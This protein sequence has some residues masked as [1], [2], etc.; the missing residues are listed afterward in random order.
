MQQGDVQDDVQGEERGSERGIAH[1]SQPQHDER[2]PGSGA[3]SLASRKGTLAGDALFLESCPRCAYATDPGRK[4]N[5][6]QQ[7]GLDLRVLDPSRG[8]ELLCV[9]CGYDLSSLQVR[10]MCPECATPVVSS[11]SVSR[12]FML[13]PVAHL[14]R[15]YRGLLWI[16]VAS[17]LAVSLAVVGGFVPS[18]MVMTLG[19]PW[20]IGF[21][22]A[23]AAVAAVALAGWWMVTSEPAGRP[24]SS[25]GSRFRARWSID[26]RVSAAVHASGRLGALLCIALST[27][28]SVALGTREYLGLFAFVSVFIAW[29]CALLLFF[30]GANCLA[31][32]GTHL[33]SPRL[34]DFGSAAAWLVP[35]FSVVLLFLGWIFWMINPVT[36][37]PLLALSAGCMPL[38][39]LA[40]ALSCRS[41]LARAV[42]S[43]SDAVAGR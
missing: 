19:S 11:L 13:A 14:R 8:R 35:I 28:P 31:S 6:C 16:S 15:I 33:L 22:A 38:C 36:S 2:G 4:A 40:L 25:T 12:W 3:G 21:A 34:K 20:Q 10:D 29:V 5:F 27:L 7:C 17:L 1:Q 43:V 24:A 32:L 9:G 41:A 37:K 30:T 18:G 42:P 23:S 26:V 39:M